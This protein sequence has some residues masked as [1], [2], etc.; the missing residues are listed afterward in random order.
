MATKRIAG[1][2]SALALAILTALPATIMARQGGV[3]IAAGDQLVISVSTGSPEL[4]K[5]VVV[6]VDG[7][8]DYPYLHRVKAAGMTTRELGLELAKRLNPDYAVDPT[9][10]VEIAESVKKHFSIVGEVRA[11]ASYP[12][13]GDKKLLDALALAGW[14]TESASDKVLIIRTSKS[15]EPLPAG[16]VGA[17]GTIHIDIYPL[18]SGADLT[19]N[20]RIQDGD[21]INVLKAEPV[22]ITGYVKSVGAYPVRRGM[23]VSQALA[24]AGGISDKGKDS[25]IRIERTENGKKIP[26]SVKDNKTEI[27][28]PGDTIIVPARIW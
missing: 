15:V 4:S 20:V 28:K 1:V 22:Y 10:T 23:T 8:F 6:D 16:A 25:G 7:S 19:N 14:L 18:L 17:D 5:R 26:I 9:V 11:P 21:T 2:T 24:L 13:D 27:V 12:I 3:Q